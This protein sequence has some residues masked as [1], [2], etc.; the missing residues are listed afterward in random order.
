MPSERLLGHDETIV[1]VKVL[2]LQRHSASKNFV[3]KYKALR[4][5]RHKN[6][7]RVITS[8]S[9]MNFQ[10]NH[11]KT[12]VYEFMEN[13]NLEKWLHP[14]P[15]IEEEDSKIQTLTILHR[16]NIV[17]DMASTMDYLHH[18]CQEPILPCNLKPSNVL[19]DNNMT[20]C[21][22]DFRLL[23]FLPKVWNK[24]KATRLE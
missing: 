12:T 22:G 13:R 20:A 8:C 17:I 24:M 1:A 19:L 9:D 4:N 21:V 10:G 15:N 2:N 11:F 16:L 18:Q 3:V 23:K 6:L 14:A 5:N 7:D